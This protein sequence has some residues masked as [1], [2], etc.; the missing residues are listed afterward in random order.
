MAYDDAVC[1]YISMHDCGRALAADREVVSASFVTPYPPGFPV[2]VPG[3]LISEDILH[4][5]AAVDVKEIHG[6][7]ANH[8]FRVFNAEAL[9]R[10]TESAALNA[11][12]EVPVQ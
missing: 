4:Y 6:Y 3:Q 8:G 1:D 2:L 9:T 11:V 5:L 12:K 7:D 10:R